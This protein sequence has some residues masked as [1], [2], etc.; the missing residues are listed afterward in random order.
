MKP[1]EDLRLAAR[2]AVP[3]LVTADSRDHRNMC[4]RLIHDIGV[5][6]G[7]PFVTFS[8]DGPHPAAVDAD[9]MPTPR[10]RDTDREDVVL[11]RQFERARGGTLF[12]DDIAK[13]RASAQAQ[14][15]SLL[16]ERA[17]YGSQV[18]SDGGPVRV[19]AGASRHLDM[20]RAT[21]AFCTPLFYRL[22]LIHINLIPRRADTIAEPLLSH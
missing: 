21:G 18:R 17:R 7:G 4:A 10:D 1:E 3:V 9:V 2:V 12:I 22:N 5:A 16:E 6:G 15:L 8:T 19:V 11:R 14:L 13:L 20:E